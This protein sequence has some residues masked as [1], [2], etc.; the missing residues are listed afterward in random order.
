[1]TSREVWLGKLEKWFTARAGWMPYVAYN[2]LF[3]V[4][5][6]MFCYWTFP[7]DRVATYLV[8][9]VAQS[10]RGYSLEIGGLHPYWLSGVELTNVV[11][12]KDSPDV[13][14]AARSGASGEKPVDTAFRVPEARVR[15]GLFSL[16]FG[17]KTLN[18]DFELD[19]GDIDGSLSDDGDQ[20]EIKASIQGVDLAKLGL[21]DTLL[22][23]PVRG[24]LNGEI[25]LT[26]AR[27]P[28]QTSG[29]VELNLAQLTVGDGKAKVKVG[30]MGG[31]T[32]DPLEAGTLKLEMDVKEGVGSVKRISTDG[33]DLLL[34]GSGEMRFAEPLINT[35]VSLLVNVRFTD[36]Y[37][38]KSPRTQAMFSLLDNSGS[39]QLLAAKMPDGA[40]QY[41]VAG[42]L[43]LL[44]PVPEGAGA[45][46]AA[47]RPTALPRAPAPSDDEE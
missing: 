24:T 38:N 40:L 18:F 30:G 35:R 37:R 17:G 25:D 27:D 12:H 45:G 26:L 41:R 36:N 33:K 43:A 1:M 3:W 42:T 31:L 28:K 16:L 15:M 44:R 19:G 22:S 14:A 21:F 39:P 5:F 29:K 11:L 2:M 46:A 4:A 47:P 9:R 23:L 13:P 6:W 7:Y 8:D 10:G 32:L 34:K 20:K